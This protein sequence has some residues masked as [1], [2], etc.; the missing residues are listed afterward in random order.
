MLISSAFPSTYLRAADIPAG[1]Q[2]VV[3]VD[4][5]EIEDVGG[6]N[7]PADQKPVLYFAGKQKGLVLNQTNSHVIEAAYGDETD[8]WHGQPLALFQTTTDFKGTVVP[9]LRVKLP[10]TEPAQQP[11]Q[12]ANGGVPAAQTQRAN[13]AAPA[14]DIPF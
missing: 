3:N 13:Q 14:G 5:V 2:V 6:N 10:V 12:N 11:P 1:Q 7:N 9:C 4:R 8:A